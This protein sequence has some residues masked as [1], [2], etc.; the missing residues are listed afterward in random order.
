MANKI[1]I[2]KR[3]TVRNGT[4]FDL[5]YRWKGMRYR[6]LLGYNLTPEEAQQ[7]AITMI[8]KIQAGKFHMALEKGGSTLEDLLPLY[9]ESF[10]L[11]N[12]VDKV[13]PRGIIEQYL[14]PHFG[15][16]PLQEI[17]P[18][19][20]H[21]YLLARHGKGASAGTIRREWQVLMRILNLAVLY[22]KLD[23]NRLQ[24][25]E[26]P[27]GDK[28]DRVADS[29]EIQAIGN[30]ASSELWRIML[31]GLHTG[32]RE[33]K[34]LAIDRVWIKLRDDGYWLCLP[35][36][37][38][39]L[40]GNP[41][42]IPLNTIALAAL[43]HDVPSLSTGQ[44]FRRWQNP[45]SFK[46][47]WTKACRDA[48]VADLHFHDL[49]HTFAT[50][51]Q[52]L[53]VDYE[54]RQALLGHKMPGMTARYS[55]GGPEWEAKIREAVKKLSDEMSDG[56]FGG[57]DKIRNVLKN[58]SGKRDLNPR[59]SPWQGDALPLSYSRSF[60][61]IPLDSSRHFIACQMFL[62]DYRGIRVI[63]RSGLQSD[64]RK[65]NDILQPKERE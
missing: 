19:H 20:G 26:V 17:K 22:E 25:V 51:L 31:V 30:V 32:L 8:H 15:T 44:V 7:E 1:T 6:P 33:S 4:A 11:K 16:I 24:A 52:R 18:D 53:G 64:K 55:H 45:R 3:L 14:L 9:W 40:K 48:Q 27:E 2:N 13:R 63:K 56:L 35:K 42:M 5:Y 41:P 62:Y 46:R 61:D 54:V 39:T 21:Q 58:W 37:A 50:R 12:R 47:Q 10:E 49:R 38:T 34:I 59:P 28:R 60:E 65:A 43:D 23:K 36:A 29:Q 57:F